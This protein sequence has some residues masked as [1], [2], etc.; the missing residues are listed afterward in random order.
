MARCS[1]GPECK[2]MQPMTEI[3]KFT[4]N[5]EEVEGRKDETIW[6]VARASGKDIIQ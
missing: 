1:V 5:G 6:Q 4:P 3:T 2:W